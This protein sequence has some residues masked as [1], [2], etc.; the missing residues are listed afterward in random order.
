MQDKEIIN[1]IF[2][3]RNSLEKSGN[4][5]IFQESGLTVSSYVP[6]KM[7]FYKLAT[8]AQMKKIFNETVASLGQKIQ[9]LE[10]MGLVTRQLDETDRRKWNF[11]ITKKGQV[12]L[13]KIEKKF[14][15]EA[16]EF[17]SDFS[18][19]EKEDFWKFLERLENNLKLQKI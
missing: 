15:K 17:F 14:D 16:Q 5:N 18:K 1:K 13:E 2:S 11:K 3:I 6:L 12:V 10:K 7:I 4:E 19:K 9:K 8:I